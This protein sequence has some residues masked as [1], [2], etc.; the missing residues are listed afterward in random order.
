M[1]REI[2]SMVAFISMARAASP[3][4]FDTLGPTACMPRRIP[5]SFSEM[6]LRKPSGSLMVWALPR[7][8]K[9][10]LPTLIS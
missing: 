3:M 6:S 7:A 8:V 9:G 10:N 1:V 4:M 2:S 5:V